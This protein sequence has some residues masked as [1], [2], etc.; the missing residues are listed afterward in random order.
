VCACNTFSLSDFRYTKS[1]TPGYGGGPAPLEVGSQAGTAFVDVH[2][3]NAYGQTAL[4][5]AV[6]HGAKQAVLLLMRCGAD[7][8]LRNNS[9][10]SVFDVTKDR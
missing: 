3:R 6:V 9:G 2:M 7:P 1:V 5:L 8:E 10:R 4:H